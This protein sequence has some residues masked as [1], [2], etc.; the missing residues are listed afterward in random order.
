[1]EVSAGTSEVVEEA[2]VSGAKSFVIKM[3]SLES[4]FGW[5][6]SRR[7]DGGHEM[8]FEGDDGIVFGYEP[9][10]LSLYLAGTKVVVH[11]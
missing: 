11:T 1:M 8:L 4:E 10:S 6:N 9:S 2:V 3:V 7:V 5:L